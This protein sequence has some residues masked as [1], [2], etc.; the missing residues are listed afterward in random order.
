[1]LITLL[2]CPRS[3]V[4]EPV[5]PNLLLA[6][7]CCFTMHSLSLLSLLLPQR[8]ILGQPSCDF[9][10]RETPSTFFDGDHILPQA[11]SFL[12]VR[13]QYYRQFSS[14]IIPRY[15]EYVPHTTAVVRFL[16]L[17]KTCVLTCF[18]PGGRHPLSSIL[19]RSPGGE[20]TTRPT[21]RDPARKPRSTSS[22][23]LFL[24]DFCLRFSCDANLGA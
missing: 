21:G 3:A 18:H 1:M 12:G 8:V 20:T 13:I 23:S 6:I 14:K 9:I 2:R 4:K 10:H 22:G 11:H 16:P 7:V 5:P 24:Q 15:I 17:N 19:T